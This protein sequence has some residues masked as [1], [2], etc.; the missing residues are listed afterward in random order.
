MFAKPGFY[1]GIKIRHALNYANSCNVFAIC[2]ANNIGFVNTLYFVRVT[3]TVVL[4]EEQ[5]QPVTYHST[6]VL[7]VYL[8]E[9]HY[10]NVRYVNW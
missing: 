1:F 7:M 10:G 3:H 8:L 4:L 5:L 6:N 9:E 2:R